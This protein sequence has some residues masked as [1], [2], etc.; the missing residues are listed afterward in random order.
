MPGG[1]PGAGGPG[2][3]RP[4]GF[5]QMSDEQRRAMF[6]KMLE[7]LPADARKEVQKILGKKKVEDLSGEERRALFAKIRELTGQGGGGGN[8]RPPQGDPLNP[9]PTQ[10]D[11]DRENAKLPLAPEEDNQLKVLLR[12]GLLADVE[13][14]VERIPDAINIPNQAVFDKDGKTIVYV[15]GPKGFDAREVKLA[16]RSESLVVVASGLKPG[17][18]IAMSDP[19]AKKDEKKKKEDKGGGSKGPAAPMSGG[20]RGR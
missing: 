18:S 1:M 3:G 4:G 19:F 7:S 9:K 10:A 20:G 17:E 8:A 2:G 12:P 11:I 6:A 15:L 14:I 5:Q 13:I 16:K